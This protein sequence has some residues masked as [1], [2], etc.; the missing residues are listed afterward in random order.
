MGGN[1]FWNL[2][3]IPIP[4]VGWHG[5]RYNILEIFG[6]IL[7]VILLCCTGFGEIHVHITMGF[8]FR[9]QP[10]TLKVNQKVI[11]GCGNQR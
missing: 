10:T 2:H 4:A 5:S 6:A 1:I 9:L 3:E 7:P 11:R 8:T